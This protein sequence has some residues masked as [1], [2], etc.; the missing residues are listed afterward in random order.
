LAEKHDIE[1]EDTIGETRA[2]KVVNKEAREA[3]KNGF[4]PRDLVQEILETDRKSD[5][6][7]AILSKHLEATE[8]RVKDIKSRLEKD[9]AT[10]SKADFDDLMNERERAFKE[11]ADA[12]QASRKL[13]TI[14]G[15]QLN[16][17]KQMVTRD[18][19]LGDLLSRKREANGDQELTEKQ[20]KEV[21]DIF[22]E[23]EKTR[24]AL[25]ERISRLEEDNAKL[26]AESKVKNTA[27]ERLRRK[28]VSKEKLAEER[29]QI[30]DDFSK[31][32][33]EMRTS[34]ALNSAGKAT[35]E[36]LSAAAPYVAKMVRNLAEE[37]IVELKDVVG[38]VK[39]ELDLKDLS[40]REVTDLIGGVYDEKKPT[41]SELSERVS[42]LKQQAKLAAQIEDLENGIKRVKPESSAAAKK[43]EQVDNLR[44]RL[45]ELNKGEEVPKEEKDLNRYKKSKQDQIDELNKKIASGDYSK[46]EPAKPV[47]LDP[48]A[49]ALRRKYDKLKHEFDLGVERD[50]LAQRTKTER[51]K[52]NILN[53]ASLPRALKA[54]LDFS[55]PGRQGLLLSIGH[56]EAAKVA[57]K[58]MFGQTFSEERYRNWL[59]DLKHT[60]LYDLMMN[61]DLYLSDKTN[62]QLLAREEMFT[63]NLAERIPVLG[64]AVAGAERAYTAYL[65]VIRSQV[66]TSEAGKLLE[67]GYTFENNPEVFKGIAKVINVLS[68]RGDIPEFLG[69]KQPA[70]LSNLLFSPRFMASRLQTLYL[71]ADPRLPKEARILAAKD[72]GKTL[73][74]AATIL[75]MAA[76]AGATVEK[77]PR[78]SDFLKMKFGNTR[79]D[80][81]GGLTPYVVFLSQELSGQK[82]PTSNKGMIYLNSKKFGSPTRASLAM[83]F[84]RGKMAPVPGMI[85]NLGE[86][87][88]LIGNEY[89]LWPNV[90]QEFVPLPFTDVYDAYKVG[91]WKNSLEVLLPAQFG[92]GVS[93][94]DSNAKKKH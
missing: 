60:D 28:S 52:D 5:T 21:N 19:S 64:K 30:A 48:E 1:L 40:D 55:A 59:S 82:K 77:D 63:S 43:N 49:L 67:R 25:E 2:K 74:T 32:L 68:G 86:G 22:D 4:D 84:M 79:Y 15:R 39:E 61:S 66:F 13:Q 65:N 24:T 70:I 54:T 71:W 81:L 29:K 44:K 94:Y 76:L 72:I 83:N 26:K 91:G 34:G 93:S 3:I 14:S 20:V 47:T 17:F 8:R 23:L 78:S 87:K 38:R 35:L 56:P 51:L 10:M 46:P 89:H 12:A 11:L 45:A 50:K 62:I 27:V 80:I 73:G 42:S 85:Y 31:K 57:M 53:I 58:E 16:A 7:V 37:G 75:T 69:G 18:Y 90:P 88:D 41:K 92:I 33:K 9:G 6:D 36:F